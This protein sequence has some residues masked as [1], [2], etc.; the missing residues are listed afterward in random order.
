LQRFYKGAEL[1]LFVE[2]PTQQIA[3]QLRLLPDREGPITLLRAFGAMPFWHEA[4]ENVVAHPWLIYAELMRSVDP[5]A[6]EAANELKSE[7]LK[8]WSR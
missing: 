8:T 1:V 6:H 7:F 3:R 4:D 2:N 5:R